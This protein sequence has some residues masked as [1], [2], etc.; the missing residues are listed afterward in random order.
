MTTMRASNRRLALAVALAAGAGWAALA[1]GCA[2]A[3]PA[4]PETAVGIERMRLLER[5]RMGVWLLD[6]VKGAHSNAVLHL[7]VDAQGRV[8]QVRVAQSSGTGR[9]DDAAVS[10]ARG[11]RFEP[12]RVDDAA[13]PVTVVLPMRLPRD[14]H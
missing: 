4:W 12:Y 1:S 5:P 14:R 6:P 7:H 3:D 13:L 9:L 2:T 8:V 11:L 10:W